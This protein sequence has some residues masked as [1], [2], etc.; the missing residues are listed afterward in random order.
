MPRRISPEP[1]PPEII[2]RGRPED[3]ILE[4][5]RNEPDYHLVE[6]GSDV[7]ISEKVRE[8]VPAPA[9]MDKNNIGATTGTVI[10]VPETDILDSSCSSDDDDVVKNC[11][12]ERLGNARGMN[13]EFC[14]E[15]L[16]WGNF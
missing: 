16:I 3:P 15:L 12:A 10:H 1:L 14:L 13:R 8:D 2:A 11:D 7:L 9:P 6:S 5:E 4:A